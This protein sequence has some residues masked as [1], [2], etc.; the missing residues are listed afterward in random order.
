MASIL[1]QSFQRHQTLEEPEPH[2]E[3]QACLVRSAQHPTIVPMEGVR[4][5]RSL[6][7]IQGD[8]GHPHGQFGTFPVPDSMNHCQ[9]RTQFQR[10]D[11]PF[12]PSLLKPGLCFR[13]AILD[14][15]NPVATRNRAIQKESCHPQAHAT[16][17]SGDI[18]E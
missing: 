9:R 13:H 4:P 12:R 15:F 16:N 5:E 14:G 2:S 8:V 18:P 6:S 17:R 10:V 11:L 1:E 7:A 3:T